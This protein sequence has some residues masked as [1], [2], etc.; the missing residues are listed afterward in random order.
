M[1]Y[2]IEITVFPEFVCVSATGKYSFADLPGFIAKLRNITI[3]NDRDKLLIDCSQLAVEM[4]ETERFAGGRT[5]AQLFQQDIKAALL[6]PA[7]QVTKLGELAA[8]NRGTQLL[9]TTSETEALE[10]LAE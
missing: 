5:I 3:G 6:M 7:G 1:E 9:V 2:Q 10:W 8:L 4:T